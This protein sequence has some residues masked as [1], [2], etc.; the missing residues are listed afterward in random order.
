MTMIVRPQKIIFLEGM[1]KFIRILS[2]DESGESRALPHS[3]D[4]LKGVED[5]FLMVFKV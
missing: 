4:L 3:S 2:P 5:V 1:G